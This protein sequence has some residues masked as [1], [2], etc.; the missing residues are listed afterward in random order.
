MIQTSLNLRSTLVEISDEE[1][2][3]L[4]FNDK[5]RLW[6][7]TEDEILLVKNCIVENDPHG[8]AD[9]CKYKFYKEMYGL[10]RSD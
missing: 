9:L 7:R 3:D 1:A 6:V 2:I 5:D 4:Y 8:L 10:S